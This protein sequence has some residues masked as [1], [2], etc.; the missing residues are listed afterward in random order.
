M[1]ALEGFSEFAKFAFDR[2]CAQDYLCEALFANFGSFLDCP[3]LF[4]AGNRF[5]GFKRPFDPVKDR[6]RIQGAMREV[7]EKLRRYGEATGIWY[8]LEQT[9]RAYR[10]VKPPPR[11]QK[12]TPPLDPFANS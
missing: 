11:K 7:K 4:N 2:E 5:W 8:D 6:P 10:L 3:T 12:K 9:P 1:T